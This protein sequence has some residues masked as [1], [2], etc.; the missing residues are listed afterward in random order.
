MNLPII[1]SSLLC[2]AVAIGLTLSACTDAPTAPVPLDISPVANRVSPRVQCDPDNAGISLPPGFCAVVV[3]D[4]VIDGRPALA[5]HLAVTPSGD[6]FV[7]INSPRNRNPSFGII[8]LRDTDGDGRADE[9]SRFSPGLGG[10]GIAWGEAKLYFGANDRVLR[11]QLPAGRLTPVRDPDVVVSGLPNTGDHISKTV[12][13][14]DGQRLFVNIG[15][16]SNA[17]QVA[18][19]QAQSPG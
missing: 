3:A 13:L 19:R 6:V 10:S 17:C 2:P 7:A 1:R 9:Q 5:R 16:A 11:F 12:V 8:G 4:L 14:A 15:S 18:N